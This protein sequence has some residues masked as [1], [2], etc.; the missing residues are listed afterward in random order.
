M[1]RFSYNRL[2][3]ILQLSQTAWKLEMTW[4]MAVVYFNAQSQY[5][6]RE[7]KYARISSGWVLGKCKPTEQTGRRTHQRRSEGNGWGTG[8]E[9]A[10]ADCGLLGKLNET[11][12]LWNDCHTHIAWNPSINLS[13]L[14]IF[15]LRELCWKGRQTSQLS[16]GHGKA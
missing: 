10:E 9:T 15:T 7:N 13:R 1:N 12:V 5:I 11:R 8:K 6:P 3:V 4:G 14:Q 16:G 2:T